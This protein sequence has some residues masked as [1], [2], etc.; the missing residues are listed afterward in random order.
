MV[1]YQDEA[2]PCV[3]KSIADSSQVVPAM[4]P[5]LQQVREVNEATIILLVHRK[6]SWG[7]ASLRQVQTQ[8]Q[9]KEKLQAIHL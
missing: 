7:E 2:S 6:I 3:T 8:A 5:I 9:A 1:V 4:G